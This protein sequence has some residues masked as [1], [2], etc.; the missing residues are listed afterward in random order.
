MTPLNFKKILLVA[1]ALFLAS[2]S[3]FLI[4]IHYPKTYN[5]D[6]VQ[7]VPTAKTFI[8]FSEM[9]NIEHPPLAKEMMAVGLA[10]AG[11]NPLGWRL[12]CTV[13]GALTLVAM[14]LL[15]TALFRNE[16]MAL[17]TAGFTGFNQLLYVQAR[18]AMLDTVMMAFLAFALAFLA[19]SF[20]PR[21]G[22]KRALIFWA[23]SGASFGLAVACKWYAL[24]PMFASIV[25]IFFAR[26]KKFGGR[27]PEIKFRWLLI[28]FGALPAVIY[29]STFLPYCFF[30]TNP[31]SFFDLWSFQLKMYD[32]QLR[33]VGDHPYLSHW[34]SWPFMKRPI[35]YA[36][37]KDGPNDEYIRGVLLLGN[38]MVVWGGLLALIFCAYRWYKKRNFVDFFIV[39][40]YCA[41]YF[42]WMF[43]PRKVAFYYYYYPAAFI[44][45]LALTQA[46]NQDPFKKINH[47]R[48]WAL[49][50]SAIFFFYFL[51]VLGAFQIGKGEFLKWMWF[52][53][54]I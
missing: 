48:I 43:F 22:R 9:R 20:E 38:P 46:L 27:W 37:D 4:N 23:A 19:F 25:M 7:Y 33:V 24:Y 18:I 50:M 35:W 21:I 8:D 6:E 15:A 52:T 32:G 3:L 16:Q 47:M 30:K 31:L 40:F 5:F 26:F 11:D 42:C 45:G 53:S 12:S 2:E 14:Y 54:W 36:F 41:M 13:F 51:P 34:A 44:L 49:A 39:Y 29:F 28:T 1:L 10:I 17:L